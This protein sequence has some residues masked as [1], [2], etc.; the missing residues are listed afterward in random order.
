MIAAGC[1]LVFKN[2]VE[3]IQRWSSTCTRPQ[4]HALEGDA[5]PLMDLVDG[6]LI[7]YIKRVFLCY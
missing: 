6:F 3:W 1:S 5:I 7:E 4:L 2:G